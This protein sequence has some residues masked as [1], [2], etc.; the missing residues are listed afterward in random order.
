MPHLILVRH[1]QSEWNL[2]KRFTGWVDVKLSS[3]GKLEACKAGESIKEQNINIDYF[4][5]SFQLRAINTLK[6]IKDTL[7]NKNEIIKAWE[8]NERHYGALTGLN[9][10][11]I[12]KKIGEKKILELRRSWNIRP[13][14][15]DRNSPYHPLNIE[16]YK[17]I[18]KKNVPDTESLEDTFNRVV[19]YYKHEI[20]NKLAKQKNILISAHGNSIRALCKYLFK[21]DNKQIINLEIPTGNP[22]V[23]QLDQKYEI[24]NCKYLIKEKARDLIIF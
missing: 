17:S 6:L 12:K 23:I 2:E 11:E 20:E 5:S 10:D 22:L 4:Y 1:G 21:L 18:S 14:P 13:E 3:I 7:R 19:S 16:T 8:L 15:L 24:K 9:K